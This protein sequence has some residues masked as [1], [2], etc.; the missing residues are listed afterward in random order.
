MVRDRARVGYLQCHATARPLFRQRCRVTIRIAVTFLQTKSPEAGLRDEG[1]PLLGANTFAILDGRK[2]RPNLRPPRAR[3]SRRRPSS[4][5]PR[6]C[7]HECSPPSRAAVRGV[8]S[9][10]RTPARNVIQSMTQKGEDPQMLSRRSFLNSTLGAG[11]ALVTSK[12][13]LA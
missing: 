7:M 13:A 10:T 6:R 8:E 1:L 9:S 4:L 11:L 3:V 2:R 5:H 12:Q